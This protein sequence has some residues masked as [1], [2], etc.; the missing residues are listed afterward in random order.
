MAEEYVE[1]PYKWEL[2]NENNIVEK[3]NESLAEGDVK[4]N[5][6]WTLWEQFEP[7][8]KTHSKQRVEY[9]DKYQFNMRKAG[10][11]NSVIGYC[12]LSNNVPHFNLLNFFYDYIKQ[13]QHSYLIKG[14]MM[15][16]NSISLFK[17]GI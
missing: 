15:R 3:Y 1:V 10:Y 5:Y 4:L 12:R 13:E 7:A 2:D 14:E 11:F 6:N 17:Q 8:D 16:V 9:D